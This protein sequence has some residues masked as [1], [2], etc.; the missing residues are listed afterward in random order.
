MKNWNKPEIE[1]IN[2]SLTMGGL[3]PDKWENIPLDPNQ[4]EQKSYYVDSI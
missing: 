1:E 3:H 2:V 4:V